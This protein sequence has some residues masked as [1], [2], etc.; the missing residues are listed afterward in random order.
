MAVER[1]PGLTPFDHAVLASFEV[2]DRG[3]IPLVEWR[4]VLGAQYASQMKGPRGYDKACEWLR[5]FLFELDLGASKLIHK[6]AAGH[7]EQEGAYQEEAEEPPWWHM[8]EG[9]P[10]RN[11][12]HD[13]DVLESAVAAGPRPKRGQGLQWG[14]KRRSSVPS[15]QRS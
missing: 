5:H 4:H 15:I 3:A 11:R 7:E 9:K 1:A 13:Q 8:D 14:D 12:K 6:D 10:S 2:D